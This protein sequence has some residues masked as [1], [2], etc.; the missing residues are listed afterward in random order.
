MSKQIVCDLCS[1]VYQYEKQLARVVLHRHPSA[2][3]MKPQAYD[4]C[5]TCLPLPIKQSHLKTILR[6]LVR[7]K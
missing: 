6:K 5:T 7:I 1:T 2:C 4:I 3:A